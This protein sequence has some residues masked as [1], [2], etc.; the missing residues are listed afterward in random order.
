MREDKLDFFS[1]IT[2]TLTNRSSLVGLL[3]L[4]K[5]KIDKSSLIID[6]Y[7]RVVIGNLTTE[8]AG[9]S[10]RVLLPV[11]L[12]EEIKWPKEVEL[13]ASGGKF[14]ASLWPIK[15]DNCDGWLAVLGQLSDITLHQ[16]DYIYMISLAAQ[17]ELAKQKEIR[18]TDCLY[19]NEFIRDLVFNNFSNLSDMKKACLY[20]NVDITK[21]FL[22]MVIAQVEENPSLDVKYLEV[23]LEQGLKDEGE[24]TFGQIGDVFVLLK[25]LE[26]QQSWYTEAVT[27]HSRLSSELP[28]DILCGVGNLCKSLDMV[29]RGYQEAKVALDLG[30]MLRDEGK[31]LFFFKE[32]GAIRLF[33]NQRIQDLEDFCEEN[34]GPIL[35]YDKEDNGELLQTLQCFLESDCNRNSCTN[36]LFIHINTLRYRLKLIEKLL[37]VDLDSNECRFNLIAALKALTILR[38]IK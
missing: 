4:L 21:Q 16:Q 22:L 35:H 9:I 28:L 11:S 17:I 31:S 24:C 27:I 30:K 13:V 12:K 29:Y 5:K 7:G 18:E 23:E 33:Y 2:E 25:A 32:L 1:E 3:L 14:R 19:K 20:W 37:H 38:N 36:K 6:A 34:L 26:D 15:A 10:N 8:N